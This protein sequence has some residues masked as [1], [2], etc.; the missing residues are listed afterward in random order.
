MFLHN[1]RRRFTRSHDIE[2]EHFVVFKYNGHDDLGVKVFDR[3]ICR[4][5]YRS[6]EDD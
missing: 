3:I 1:G 6:D 5:H 4:R 2:D